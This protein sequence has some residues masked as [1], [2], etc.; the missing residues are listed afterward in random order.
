MESRVDADR[1]AR[2]A[3]LI[4]RVRNGAYDFDSHEALVSAADA[5]LR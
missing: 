5:L 4:L 1:E 3:G 2:L